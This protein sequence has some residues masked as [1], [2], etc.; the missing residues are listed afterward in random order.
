MYMI[1]DDLTCI[2]HNNILLNTSFLNKRKTLSVIYA[3]ITR[4]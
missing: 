2:Y 4:N 3:N 1:N